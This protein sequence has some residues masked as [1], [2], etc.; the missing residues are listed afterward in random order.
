MARL[1]NLSLPAAFRWLSS[2][3][4]PVG[5][6]AGALLLRIAYALIAPYVDPFL[7]QSPLLGDA[8]GYDSIAYNLI[9][10]NGYAQVA[11]TPDSFW[12]PLY[13]LYLAV[14]YTLFGH[15]LVA[16]RLAQTVL[17][18]LLPLFVYY[19]GLRLFNPRVARLS[20]L[21]LVIYP[22]IL[23]WGSWV[24]S[25]NLYLALLGLTLLLC[26][27]VQQRPT[28]R[29]ALFIGV[30]LGLETLAKPTTLMHLPFFIIWFLVCL[31]TISLRKRLML[32]IAA[33]AMLVLII[34]PWTI[35]NYVTFHAFIIGSTNGGYTF[36]GAN[37]PNAFGG[38]Y[39]HFPNAIP[40]LDDAA[41]Q[42]E[43][44]RLGMTWIK[45]NPVDFVW[46][47]GQKMRRLASP[48][49]IAS[50]PE[51]YHVPGELAVR[52][53]YTLYLLCAGF[54]I[55]LSLRR[56][57]TFFV[58]YIPILGVLTSTTLFYGDVRYTLP[59]VPSLVLFSAFAGVM[60]LNK[61]RKSRPAS[62]IALAP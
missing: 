45:E 32:G 48:L 40:G 15:S 3:R 49:S 52:I 12:S 24:I 1:L 28:Y 9:T 39:E 53:V 44:Y 47:V 11:G 8:A 37:N 59:A 36:Y 27:H 56:W 55:I 50:N 57:R 42:S 21:A 26:V 46:L 10:G 20:G 4:W 6:F 7:I 16:A 35:R 61:F 19:I 60:V 22:Y 18:A 58:L 29:T 54:G 41:L 25:E 23:Y 38:H 43:Y 31:T 30:C 62:Q 33:A 2:H 14:V 17:G 34:T 51:D 13:P 5:L